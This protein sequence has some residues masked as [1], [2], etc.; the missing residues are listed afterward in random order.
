MF[1]KW[2]MRHELIIMKWSHIGGLLFHEQ[3]EFDSGLALIKVE[4]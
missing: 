3:E 1:G 2:Q 4:E